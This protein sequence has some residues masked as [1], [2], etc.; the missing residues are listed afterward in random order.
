MR[1]LSLFYRPLSL[2]NLDAAQPAFEQALEV[3]PR[4]VDAAS[5]PNGPDERIPLGRSQSRD[6]DM[7]DAPSNALAKLSNAI[8]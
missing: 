1:G 6:Q 4:S 8:E 7:A 3:D 2:A 5:A